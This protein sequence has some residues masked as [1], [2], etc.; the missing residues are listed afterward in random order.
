MSL[1]TPSLK[2]TLFKLSRLGAWRTATL[3]RDAKDHLKMVDELCS[4]DSLE[5]LQVTN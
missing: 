4:S 3:K 2:G 5:G 1:Y